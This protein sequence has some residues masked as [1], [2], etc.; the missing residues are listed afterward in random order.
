MSEETIFIGIPSVKDSELIPTVLNAINYSENKDRVFIGIAYATEF[1]NKKLNDSLY[2]SLRKIENISINFVNLNKYYGAGWGRINVS[3][4]YNNQDYYLQID[5]H[6]MFDKN[7]DTKL[8]K[9][10]QD[11]KKRVKDKIVISG[12]PSPYSYN[13]NGQRKL[14][15]GSMK[16]T[17]PKYIDGTISD[18]FNIY[19]DY[20]NML[21]NWDD[22]FP[23]EI[24]NNDKEIFFPSPKVSGG[25][26]FGGKEFGMNYRKYYPYAPLFYD[27]EIIQSVELINDGY[28]IICP[29]IDIPISHLYSADINEKG[30]ERNIT[31]PDIN[32]FQEFI[33]KYEK[34]LLNNKEKIN[35]YRKKTGMNLLNNQVEFEMPKPDWFIKNES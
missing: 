35:F 6:T 2:N 19:K 33:K 29:S 24:W 34:Y 14:S 28:N 31:N 13:I 12:Y 9:I 32:K 18:R 27:E 7:W 3:N 21:P 22:F 11:A 26:T 4:L 5:S 15:R 30:G 8:I 20:T 16:L 17:C 23:E 1:S 10:F 25:F